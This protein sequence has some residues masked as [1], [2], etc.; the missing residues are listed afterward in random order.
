MGRG[1]IRIVL[2]VIDLVVPCCGE[3]GGDL[4]GKIELRN[5]VG[6]KNERE[7]G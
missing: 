1:G 2:K 5:G 4:S 6:D 3:A 7:A